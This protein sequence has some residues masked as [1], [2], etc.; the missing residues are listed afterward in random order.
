MGKLRQVMPLNLPQLSA[1]DIIAHC[2]PFRQL[3][4]NIQ[5]K[6]R[7]SPASISRLPIPVPGRGL[8]PSVAE[9]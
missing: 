9:P 6:G 2:E 4:Q 3:K 5:A 7:N 8:D 1:E